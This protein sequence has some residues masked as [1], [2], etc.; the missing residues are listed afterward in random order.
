[1]V[2]RRQAAVREDWKWVPRVLVFVVADEE[3]GRL[4]G[5]RCILF[6]SLCLAGV[7][8]PKLVE[9]IVLWGPEFESLGEVVGSLNRILRRCSQVKYCH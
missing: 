9:S 2:P 8:R 5:K 3:I 7:L 6:L 1:M 4:T